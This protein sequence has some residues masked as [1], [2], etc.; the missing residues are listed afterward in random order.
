MMEPSS[1]HRSLGG[2]KLGS[3]EPA[4]RA[5][6]KESHPEYT[7]EQIIDFKSLMDYRLDHIE[8]MIGSDS[9]TYSALNSEVIESIRANDSIAELMLS[10]GEGRLTL[11]Q[12][13]ADR[14]ANIGGS[15]PFIIIFILCLIAWILANTFAV[16]SKNF[17]PYPFILLNLAL[18]CLA[19]IQAPIIMMSQNRQSD[20]DRQ[21]EISDYK[22]NL[23]AEIEI[24]LLH[25]KLDYLL[26]EPWNHLMS[27]QE[28]QVKLLQQLTEVVEEQREQG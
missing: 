17:D 8:R 23:K 12:R 16:F 21:R 22:V 1:F 9:E 14:L 4:I 10:D 18:S 27:T 15:W 11:G 7:D 24:E 28:M 13:A 3:I 6:I 19:A 2:E 26:K 25:K 5:L 20:R